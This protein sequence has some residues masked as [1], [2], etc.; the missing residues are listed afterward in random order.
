MDDAV[1]RAVEGAAV[2]AARQG[3]ISFRDLNELL[4]HAPLTVGQIEQLL[5]ALSA[6]H[7]HLVD[8]D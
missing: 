2:L 7:I 1:R 4:G 6:R 3:N 8:D 5:A